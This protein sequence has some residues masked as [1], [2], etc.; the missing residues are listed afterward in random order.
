M[1]NKYDFGY[2]QLFMEQMSETSNR[3]LRAKEKYYKNEGVKLLDSSLGP[4]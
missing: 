4:K 2:K 3:I 1:K